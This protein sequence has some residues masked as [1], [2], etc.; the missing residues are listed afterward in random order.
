MFGAEGGEDS[1]KL[2]LGGTSGSSAVVPDNENN[3]LCEMCAVH[4][5][6]LAAVLSRTR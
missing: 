4:A 2:L 6:K 5:Q 3:T 1:S